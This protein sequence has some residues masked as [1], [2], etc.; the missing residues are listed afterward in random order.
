MFLKQH[1][2]GF[3]GDCCHKPVSLYLTVL[4]HLQG[5]TTTTTS[6]NKNKIPGV[7]SQSVTPYREIPGAGYLQF[8]SGAFILHQAGPQVV[9]KR[10]AFRYGGYRRV[11]TSSLWEGKPWLITLGHRMLFSLGRQTAYKRETRTKKKQYRSTE[12][13]AHTMKEQCSYVTWMENSRSYGDG[14]RPVESRRAGGVPGSGPPKGPLKATGGHPVPM[15]GARLWRRRVTASG[16]KIMI[17]VT[18]PRPLN[19]PQWNAEEFHNKKVP[20]IERL[21]KDVDVACIQEAH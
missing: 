4:S 21:H 14:V 6:N 13:L 18:I 5:N 9:G 16:R 2:C 10:E 11:I 7:Q 17:L 20:L 15:R 3:E 1:C 8:G 12:P 19:I